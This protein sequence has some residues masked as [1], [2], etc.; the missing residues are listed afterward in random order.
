MWN[1]EVKREENLFQLILAQFQVAELRRL[2]EKYVCHL[3]LAV[4]KVVMTLN[5]SIFSLQPVCILFATLFKQFFCLVCLHC[6]IDCNCSTKYTAYLTP[7]FDVATETICTHFTPESCWHNFHILYYDCVGVW[8]WT[9]FCISPFH[10]L[11]TLVAVK[12]AEKSFECLK[13]NL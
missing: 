2:W 5:S 7:T 1:S 6:H 8:G 3:E 11:L 9:A 13:W 10:P 4:Y 12:R